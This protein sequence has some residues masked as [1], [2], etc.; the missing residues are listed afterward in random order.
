MTAKLAKS[1][2]RGSKPGERRGGRRKG[3]PNKATR[4]LREVA[5]QYTEEALSALI[6][7]MNNTAEPAS[8][9]V[10]AANA[11]LDRGFGKPSQVVQGAGENGEHIHEVRWT[12]GRP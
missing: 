12:V 1:S 4:S 3:T 6:G 2:N 11:I 10:A 9:R 5:R 7:V 8:A